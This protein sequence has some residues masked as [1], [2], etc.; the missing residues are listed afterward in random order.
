[1]CAV[2]VN[3]HPVNMEITRSS[4]GGITPHKEFFFRDLNSLSLSTESTYLLVADLSVLRT[5]YVWNP[6]GDV[7]MTSLGI[8]ATRYILVRKMP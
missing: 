6:S 2:V 5:L 7:G 4:G 1:M 8:L 3:K